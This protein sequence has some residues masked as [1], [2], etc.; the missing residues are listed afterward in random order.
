MEF[1]NEELVDREK[2][3][4]R[5]LLEDFTIKQISEK[6]GLNKKTLSAHINNM[7]KKLKVKHISELIKLLRAKNINTQS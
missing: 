6:T 7:M 5:Y 3:I 4:G 2:E 1:K